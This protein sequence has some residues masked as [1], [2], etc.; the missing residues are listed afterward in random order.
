MHKLPNKLVWMDGSRG[1]ERDSKN[2]TFIKSYKA[3]EIVDS[4]NHWHC[5]RAWVHKEIT[6][7]DTFAWLNVQK[8]CSKE[9]GFWIVLLYNW[10]EKTMMKELKLNKYTNI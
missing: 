5:E 9:A 6:E 3:L 2:L 8:P 1:F 7:G 4:H 10:I